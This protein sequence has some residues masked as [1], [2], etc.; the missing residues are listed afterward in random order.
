MGG[1]KKWVFNIL[2][3]Y[4]GA[5]YTTIGMYLVAQ[6]THFSMGKVILYYSCFAIIKNGIYK[7]NQHR[8]QNGLHYNI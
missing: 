2:E 1:L 7:N 8:F 4:G 3:I 5:A 6:M